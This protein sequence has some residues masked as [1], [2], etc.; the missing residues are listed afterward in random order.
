MKLEN[1][2]PGS[3][4]SLVLYMDEIPEEGRDYAGEMLPEVLDIEAG[5][6]V[7]LNGP[8]HYS[9][10]AS[11]VSGELLVQ[12]SLGVSITM[13]C[14]R[15][16]A[17]YSTEVEDPACFLD[18]QVDETTESV[19]LTEDIR[20]AI[21]LAFP[22]YPVCSSDCKGLCPQC[23]ANKNTSECN[24]KPPDEVRWAALDGLGQKKE[25]RS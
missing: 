1:V 16:S 12:G 21:I 17:P 25:R 5:E 2:P 19:D 8:L 3:G 10:H 9:L 23:G 11:Q 7:A 22:S 15:C 14:C 4:D 13:T 20:E 18:Y 6:L 24:C